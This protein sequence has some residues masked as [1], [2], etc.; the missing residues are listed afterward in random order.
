MGNQASYE[1]VPSPAPCG[2]DLRLP[3]DG[4]QSIDVELYQCSQYFAAHSLLL[5]GEWNSSDWKSRNAVLTAIDMRDGAVIGEPVWLFVRCHSQACALSA[6]RARVRVS[7][8]W[9]ST[10]VGLWSCAWQRKN[11]L[12]CRPSL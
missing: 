5:R 9:L 3:D 7:S 12:A 4:S 8:V 6:L 2:F 10:C 11:A 1:Q